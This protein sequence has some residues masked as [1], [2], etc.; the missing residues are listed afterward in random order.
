MA[1]KNVNPKVFNLLKKKYSQQF[2]SSASKLVAALDNYFKDK[3]VDKR[4]MHVIAPRTIY[5]FFDVNI[6]NLE[7]LKKTETNL[8]YLCEFL[9]DTKG[10]EDA[11][12]KIEKGDFPSSERGSLNEE[13]YSRILENLINYQKSL[14]IRECKDMKIL[15]MDKP[16]PIDQ[17][18]V[19]VN[20]LQR[21]LK[22]KIIRELLS[23]NTGQSP[24]TLYLGFIVRQEG[25]PASQVVRDNSKLM[26]WGRLGA[27]KTTF[28]KYLALNYDAEKFQASVF[29]RLRDL[30]L[31]LEKTN[32]LDKIYTQFNANKL[33]EKAVVDNLLLTGKILVLLDGLDEVIRDRYDMVRQ[34]IGSF[35]E[36]FPKNQFI[37]TCRFGIY[38][39]GFRGFT[40]VELASFSK[41]QI[42]DFVRNW[43]GQQ[44]DHSRASRLINLF[45]EDQSLQ[46]YA[47][48]PLQLNLLCLAIDRGIEIPPRNRYELYEGSAL[49]LLE[50]WDNYRIIKR[51]K[52]KLSKAK[53]ITFL[54]KLAFDGLSST[55]KKELWR[56][57]ELED[58][59]GVILRQTSN[60]DED[61]FG[62]DCQLEVKAIE[63]HHGL[64]EQ[65]TPG[66][67]AFSS[68]AFQEYFAA[69]HIVNNPDILEE[70]IDRNLT[71]RRWKDIFLM[72]AERLPYA[73]HFFVL[74]FKKAIS[75]VQTEKLQAF[76]HWLS[77]LTT[78]CNVISPSWRAGCLA[79][80]T[81]IN[82]Y[83]NRH[84]LTSETRST[85]HE[86]A[87]ISREISRKKKTLIKMTPQYELR[88]TLAVLNTMA[89]DRSDP[90]GV[91]RRSQSNE[92]SLKTASD[93]AKE[94]LTS[95]QGEI[96]PSIDKSVVLAAELDLQGLVRVLTQLKSRI[97]TDL[98]EAEW[99][100]WAQ[101]LE[102]CMQQYLG[103]GY[104]TVLTAEEITALTDYLYINK[105][106]LECLQV[107]S[108]VDSALREE[109]WNYMLL[110]HDQIP[111]KLRNN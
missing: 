68:V 71:N 87:E 28:L 51:L 101:E 79:I 15:T 102:T 65:L 55:P 2:G 64:L 74:A 29:I 32:L 105:V 36:N 76:L 62:D 20:V 41:H 25:V 111:L 81:E 45:E 93:F 35:V 16:I 61:S 50:K 98:L 10:Y 100:S 97:P 7:N 34:K 67:H 96:Q 78:L 17:V 31:D 49:A 11:L 30:E 91:D 57:W 80:S 63:S 94:Y 43:F 27:G 5:N 14:T 42:N 9:L 59:I 53:K 23:E 47:S 12:E 6:N 54:S 1:L 95:V 56:T 52:T 24:E 104:N 19:N 84:Q 37:L 58:T 86:L 44:D 73:D 110:P 33:E 66:V 109:I 85:A 3:D 22:H 90:E 18:F 8:N 82:L 99:K 77:R 4:G 39:D 107:D 72:V 89:E 26:I 103:I 106:I 46:N 48:N 69:T 60:F 38:D 40:E 92:V 108:F 13:E 70:V 83:L 75:L 88:L 21:G